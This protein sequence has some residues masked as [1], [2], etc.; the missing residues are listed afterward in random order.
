M[1]YPFRTSLTR[2]GKKVLEVFGKGIFAYW[3][4]LKIKQIPAEQFSV[5]NHLKSHRYSVQ[6][7]YCTVIYT[8]SI[9]RLFSGQVGL[10]S[11][12]IPTVE[13]SMAVQLQSPNP[14]IRELLKFITGPCMLKWELTA[15]VTMWRFFLHENRIWSEICPWRVEDFFEKCKKKELSPTRLFRLKAPLKA[16]YHLPFEGCQIIRQGH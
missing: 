14:F 6:R 10:R 9:G 5:M 1:G 4:R 13:I 15:W 12:F 8:V 3:V 2:E 7:L 16:N 11:V